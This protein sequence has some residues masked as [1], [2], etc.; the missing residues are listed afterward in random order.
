MGRIERQGPNA[1]DL[2]KKTIGWIINAKRI[3][4]AAELEHALAIEVGSPE[5][6]EANITDM[7]QLTAYCCGLVTLDEQTTQ[8]KLVHYTTQ[9]YFEKSWKKW[10]PDIHRAIADSCLTYVAYDLFEDERF[11]APDEVNRIEL[12]YPFYSYAASYWGRHFREFPGDDMLAL[13]FLQN[14]AKVSGYYRCGLNPFSQIL[15]RPSGLAAAHIVAYFNLEHIMQQLLDVNPDELDI[16]NSENETPLFLAAY[17]GHLATAELL[18]NRGAQYSIQGTNGRTP[19]HAAAGQGHISIVALF[20]DK[21]VDIEISDSTANSPLCTAAE[22]G[23]GPVVTLLL[24][25][26]AN[27]NTKN[28]RGLTPLHLASLSGHEAVAQQL[29]NRGANIESRSN[30]G[31]HPLHTAALNGKFR[32]AKL[33]LD[34]GVSIDITNHAGET[35][36]HVASDVA[37]DGILDLKGINATIELLLERGANTEARDKDGQTPLHLTASRRNK[38]LAQVLLDH[39]ANIEARSNDGHTPLHLATNAIWRRTPVP[40]SAEFIEM[41]VDRGASVD[42]V[43]HIRVTPLSMAASMGDEAVVQLLLAKNANANI[44]DHSGHTPLFLAAWRGHYP[45]VRLLLDNGACLNPP[46]TGPKHLDLR[47][48]VGKDHGGIF[49]EA[50][51]EEGNP[52]HFNIHGRTPLHMASAGGHVSVARL[53]LDA[54]AQPD[55]QDRYGRTPL[56]NA[57]CGGHFA[58]ARL[59]LDLPDVDRHRADIW[60]ITP[61]M[62]AKKRDLRELSSLLCEADPAIEPQV[63]HSSKEAKAP[64][65]CDICLIHFDEGEE[66]YACGDFSL[67]RFCSPVVKGICLI[68]GKQLEHKIN[69]SPEIPIVVQME[70]MVEEQCVCM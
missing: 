48:A 21:G 34:E 64:S 46:G 2:A 12:E 36:L 65:L 57:V 61:A 25:R 49:W 43:S 30:N 17:Y 28:T 18:L 68:C 16:Q 27:I 47:T 40:K 32:V 37:F 55:T 62:E 35:P 9:K 19:L 15:P 54:G 11:S 6:D 66:S 3:L 1:A 29:L 13:K 22:K 4:T 42:P 56:F 26:G 31:N 39:G 58:I 70:M 45:V 5:F 10:F 7:E 20:L 38:T 51:E 33:F 53:L 44:S 50:L 52:D 67:C 60:G 59:L 8:V 41:L 23:A 14:K 24:D 69:T 63:A